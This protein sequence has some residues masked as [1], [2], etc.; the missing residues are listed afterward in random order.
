[1]FCMAWQKIVDLITEITRARCWTRKSEGAQVDLPASGLVNV[2]RSAR[3]PLL[4]GGLS[5]EPYAC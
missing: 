3:S 1:M 5:D 2:S 4:T